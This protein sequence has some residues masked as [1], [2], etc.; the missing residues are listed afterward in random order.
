[1]RVNVV[2][3]NMNPLAPR[4]FELNHVSLRGREDVQGHRIA[5]LELLREG[6]QAAP[7]G[8][9]WMAGG[10]A[11]YL[12]AVA[13]PP[14]GFN[15]TLAAVEIDQVFGQL[16]VLIVANEDVVGGKGLRRKIIAQV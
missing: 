3:A 12:G 6:Q 13:P 10:E 1:E 9:Q 15:D 7:D 8:S 14:R 11:L 4:D 16:A 2:G 5:H